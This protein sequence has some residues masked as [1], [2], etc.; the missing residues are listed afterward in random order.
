MAVPLEGPDWRA[1]MDDVRAFVGSGD[2]VRFS[3]TG[4]AAS[5][6]KPGSNGAL[7]TRPRGWR[8]HLQQRSE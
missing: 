4:M 3:A 2:L 7:L 6:F 8:A 1:S 5:A